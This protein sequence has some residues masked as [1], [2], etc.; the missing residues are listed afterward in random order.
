MIFQEI[1]QLVRKDIQLELRERY[2]INSLLLY[3]SSTIFICYLSFSLSGQNLPQP[4]WNTLFWI[5]M[6][7]SSIHTIS[8]SFGNEQLSRFYYYYYLSSP[9][10]II[11]AKI[12]Y[13]TILL[14]LIAL[15]GLGLY[16]LVLGYP[17]Q[18]H[19][20]FL[21]NLVLGTLGFSGTLTLISGISAKAGNNMTLM[22][23]LSFPIIIPMLLML[24][25]VSKQAMDGL[26]RSVSWDEL[27]NLMGLNFIV[28][29]LSYLLFPYI[30]RS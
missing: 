13:N 29:A 25:R 27:L 2:A 21:L 24:I 30:W 28:I 16:S 5:I 20:L 12:I 17:V 4:T 26:D 14:S 6:L 11:L 3:I 19:A 9:E 10:A 22:S 8:K 15:M 23:I 1:L 7:F 18:D